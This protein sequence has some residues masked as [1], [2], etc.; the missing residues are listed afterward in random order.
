MPFY[1]K[2]FLRGST[3]PCRLIAKW[4]PIA[5]SNLSYTL[6]FAVVPL[7]RQMPNIAPPTSPKVSFHLHSGNFW[8]C[9]LRLYLWKLLVFCRKKAFPSR[10]KRHLLVCTPTRLRFAH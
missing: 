3:T 1:A 5:Q 7:S 4:C 6:V 9:L 8:Q 10:A 2:F